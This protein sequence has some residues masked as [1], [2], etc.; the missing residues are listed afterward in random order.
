MQGA[1][2]LSQW[3][4]DAPANKAR[5]PEAQLWGRVAKVTE[6][7]GEAVAALISATGQNPRKPEIGSMDDVIKELLDTAVT[8]LGAVEHIT[9]NKGMSGPLLEGH[10]NHLLGRVGLATDA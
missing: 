6:E 10:L 7:A 4:D 3:V 8:A 2:R 5:D 9:G 1:A